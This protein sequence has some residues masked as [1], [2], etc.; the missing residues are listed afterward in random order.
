MLNLDV[1][2][3]TTDNCHVINVNI[4]LGRGACSYGPGVQDH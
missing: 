1:L 3:F 4:S 2:V